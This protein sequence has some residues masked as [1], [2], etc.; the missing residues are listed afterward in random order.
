MR[1]F[2]RSL[3]FASVLSVSALWRGGVIAQTA[4][5]ASE[6]ELLRDMLLRT[7]GSDAQVLPGQLPSELAI[8]LPLPDQARIIGSI[9]SAEGQENVSFYDYLIFL[10]VP[11]SPQQTTD[12]Y[13]EQLS[14]AGWRVAEDFT[15]PSPG[16]ASSGDRFIISP[17]FCQD[18]QVLNI[19]VRALANDQGATVSLQ[20]ADTADQPYSSCNPPDLPEDPR[21]SIPLPELTA[22]PN[23]QVRAFGGGGSES[24]WN[25]TANIEGS[26]TSQAL[27]NHYVSQLEQADWTQQASDTRDAIA[28]SFLTLRDEEGRP[29][30]SFLS[31]AP[32][33]EP[34]TYAAQSLSSVPT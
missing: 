8:D 27:L 31:I 24:N 16:F 22:A 11:R 13:Q 19:A 23:T 26:L 10:D 4:P 20:L 28:W 7:F 34:N 32:A 2:N 14:R 29:W 12:F 5:A 3:L 18:T 30:Q 15:S 21:T 1:F 6:Q 25:S 17:T 9:V 33:D